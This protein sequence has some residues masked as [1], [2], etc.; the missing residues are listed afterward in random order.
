MNSS[1]DYLAMRSLENFV[2]A[3]LDH[4]VRVMKRKLKKIRYRPA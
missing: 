4:L 1:G 2:A 3:G